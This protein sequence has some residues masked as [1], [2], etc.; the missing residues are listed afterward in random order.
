[1]Q[2]AVLVEPNA[3]KP[4]ASLTTGQI[5]RPAPGP[6]SVAVDADLPV[7]PPVTPAACHRFRRRNIP[8]RL[9]CAAGRGAGARH[10]APLQPR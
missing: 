6:V 4:T 2:T 5:D 10:A 1:M 3:A 7:S 8:P 9:R